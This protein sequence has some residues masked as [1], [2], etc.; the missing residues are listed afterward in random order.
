M[1]NTLLI[2]LI[3][4][5]SFGLQ[6]QIT[7]IPDSIFEQKLID[8]EIDSDGQVNGQV[9]TNDV[10]GV[11]NLDLYGLDIDDLTGIEDFTALE[12][13]N[14]SFTSLSTS[15]YPTATLDLRP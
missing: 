11:V 5:F 6:A 12:L 8:L 14:I 4:A 2:V 1:K 13:L 3:V 9:L 7:E 10:S 15:Y